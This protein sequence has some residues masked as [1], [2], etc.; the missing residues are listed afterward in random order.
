MGLHRIW[1]RGEVI[2][3]VTPLDIGDQKQLDGPDVHQ[4][5]LFEF[6]V[7]GPCREIHDTNIELDRL[8]PRTLGRDGVFR[9]VLPCFEIDLRCP[10]AIGD[11]ITGAQTRIAA[12]IF[13]D[14]KRDSLT[15]YGRA[16]GVEQEHSKLRLTTHRDLS[17][18]VSI[19]QENIATAFGDAGEWVTIVFG[20]E[21]ARRGQ[22]DEDLTMV[23]C[24][25]CTG[26]QADDDPNE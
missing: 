16:G 18:L 21:Y 10:L 19:H 9:H 6:D 11:S 17:V 23:G 26:G 5:I 15:F 12:G 2:R 8:R 1:G 24:C 14:G 25:V 20:N 4:S 13:V 7:D 22:L 3:V